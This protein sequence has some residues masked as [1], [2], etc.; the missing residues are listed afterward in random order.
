MPGD[1]APAWP[2]SQPCLVGEVSLQ[3]LLFCA[4]N[5]ATLTSEERK[6]FGLCVFCERERQ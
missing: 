4:S 3:T 2:G 5:V 1:S 6:C